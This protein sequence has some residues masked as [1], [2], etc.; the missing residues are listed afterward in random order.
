MKLPDLMKMPS[1]NRIGAEEHE[2]MTTGCRLFN[3]LTPHL[4]GLI[5]PT[6]DAFHSKYRLISL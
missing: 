6:Y 5:P 4:P 1:F 3:R 2:V